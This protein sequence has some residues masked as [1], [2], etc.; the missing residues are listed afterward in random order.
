MGILPC[1]NLL[2][3]RHKDLPGINGMHL[4]EDSGGSGEICVVVPGFFRRKWG[5][6]GLNRS[7]HHAI[8][9]YSCYYRHL[10]DYA[11]VNSKT[12]MMRWGDSDREKVLR[13]NDGNHTLRY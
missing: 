8:P 2:L 11:G 1:D 10:V 9:G 7:H 3:Y 5:N 12:K 4:L 6:P 13:M